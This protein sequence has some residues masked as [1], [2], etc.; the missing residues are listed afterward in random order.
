[1]FSV[2]GDGRRSCEGERETDENAIEEMPRSGWRGHPR[3]G[4]V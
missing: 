3:H 4:S 2:R 1:M